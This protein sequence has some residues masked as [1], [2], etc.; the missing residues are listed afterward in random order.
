MDIIPKSSLKVI[1]GIQENRIR[2]FFHELINCSVDS[3][4]TSYAILFVILSAGS[5]IWARL[6]K[7]VPT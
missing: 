4:Y 7:S 3:S 2:S 5:R 6:F 1:A